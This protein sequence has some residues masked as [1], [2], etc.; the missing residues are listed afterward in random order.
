MVVRESYRRDMVYGLEGQLHR[1]WVSA[2]IFAT[3]QQECR[4]ES[5]NEEVER[6]GVCGWTVLEGY[7]CRWSFFYVWVFVLWF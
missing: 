1:N 4:Q 2:L 7:R 5:G 6:K 3:M